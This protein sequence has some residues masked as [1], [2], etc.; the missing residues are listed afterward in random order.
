MRLADAFPDLRDGLQRQPLRIQ[1]ADRLMQL[2]AAGL[3]EPGDN[4]PGERDLAALF[5]V[6]RESVRGALQLLSARGVLEITHGARTTVARAPPLSAPGSLDLR[7]L[8]GVDDATVLGA[9]TVLEPAMAAAA[10]VNLG[11]PGLARLQTLLDAQHAM[12]HDPVRFQISDHEFHGIIFAA[13]GNSVLIGY[14]REAYSHAYVHRRTLMERQHSIP[15]TIA[16][17]ARIVAALLTRDP[18]AAAAAM[19]AH[20]ETIA[21]LLRQAQR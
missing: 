9:R 7:R 1:I 14:A 11:E 13:G 12:L 8:H 20:M 15:A 10:A 2:V 18:D 16:D 19:T 3:L 17:H 6:S 21:R 5:D 4:L